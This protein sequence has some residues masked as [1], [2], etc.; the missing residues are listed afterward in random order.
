M[1][2]N[3]PKFIFVAIPKTAGTT[4][5]YH[6]RRKYGYRFYLDQGYKEARQRNRMMIL[7]KLDD[8]L[9]KIQE[10]H[11]VIWG[12]F[13]IQK[14]IHLR[15][16]KVVFFRDPLSRVI[17]HYS[18]W[19]STPKSGINKLT[20]EEFVDAYKNIQSFFAKNDLSN[21]DFIGIVEHFDI[22]V[23]RLSDFLG[24]E[25]PLTLPKRNVT[26]KKLDINERGIQYFNSQNK[27][28][29][30]LYNEALKKF[31]KGE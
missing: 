24:Y 23:K 11:S 27:K 19:M 16:P 8:R 31:K 28:D 9:A 22:S 20:F 3:L 1:N 21:F 17:S 26:K 2:T 6:F 25:I 29:I 4:L 18:S 15:Y 10:T 5:K 7:D 12:H 13:T 30:Q 14:Y